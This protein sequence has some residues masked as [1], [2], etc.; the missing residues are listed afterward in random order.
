VDC[1]VILLGNAGLGSGDRQL[2]GMILANFLRLL[3][4]RDTLPKYIVLWN[5]GVSIAAGGSSWIEHLK[6]LQE[7][8]VEIILCRT[9]VEFLGIE[10]K[11][12]VGEIGAMA[13]IQDILFTGRVLTV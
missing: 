3:G 6:K 13:Q 5:E 11:I 8:G 2:G 7:L 1:D 10:E 9:C 4:E 12:A